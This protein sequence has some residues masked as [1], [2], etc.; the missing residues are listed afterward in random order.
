MYKFDIVSFLVI[1]DFCYGPVQ[2]IVIMSFRIA[3]LIRSVPAHIINT[4]SPV[5]LPS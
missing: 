5:Y 2:M 3:R 4:V 1:L